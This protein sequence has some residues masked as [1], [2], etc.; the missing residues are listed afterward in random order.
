M[1]Q[2]KEAA[3]VRPRVQLT[4]FDRSKTVQSELAACDINNIIAQFDRTGQ[5]PARTRDAIYADVSTVGSYQDALHAVADAKRL[6]MELP[7]KTRAEFGHDPAA[8]L[9]FCADPANRPELVK[10]GLVAPDPEP[11]LE[12]KVDAGKP[13]KDG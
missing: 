12:L 10:L 13:S 2:A 6:F 1:A 4:D 5:L 9:D 3:R 7:A 11:Q 8:F